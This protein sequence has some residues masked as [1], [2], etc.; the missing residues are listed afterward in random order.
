MSSP[1]PPVQSV[2]PVRHVRAG[3]VAFSALNSWYTAPPHLEPLFR[4]AKDAGREVMFTADRDCHIL[5][6]ALLPPPPSPLM[7]ARTVAAFLLARLMGWQ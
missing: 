5:S 1:S 4:L 6:A 3:R 7:R 2:S